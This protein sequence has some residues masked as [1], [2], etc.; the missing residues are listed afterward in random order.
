MRPATAWV[1]LQSQCF[2]IVIL[3]AC[4]SVKLFICCYLSFSSFCTVCVSPSLFSLFPLLM[5]ST[6]LAVCKTRWQNIRKER[7]KRENGKCIL[8]FCYYGFFARFSFSTTRGNNAVFLI[9]SVCVVHN[10]TVRRSHFNWIE[11]KTVS[12]VYISDKSLASR[13]APVF[14]LVLFYFVPSVRRCL[15]TV[16]L[17]GDSR[18]CFSIFKHQEVIWKIWWHT[19]YFAGCKLEWQIDSKWHRHSPLS[20]SHCYRKYE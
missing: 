14:I 1:D 10:N 20:Q 8:C 19:E 13:M 2:T 11:W 15:Y 3:C 5:F 16:G 4:V 17:V 7:T 6:L 18:A 12:V 9:I